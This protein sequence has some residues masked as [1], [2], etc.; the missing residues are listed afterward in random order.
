MSK[1]FKIR[2]GWGEMNPTTRIHGK[3]KEGRKPK[4][5]KQDRHNWKKNVDR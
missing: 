3:G 2:K 1:T 4:F 5:G